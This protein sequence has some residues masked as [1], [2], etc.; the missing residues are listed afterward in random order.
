MTDDITHQATLPDLE[1]PEYHGRKPVGM[2]TSISGVGNRITREHGI[3]DRTV[4]VVEI[5]CASAGHK[6]IDDALHYVET[7]KV[8]D[9]YE[10]DRDAGARL[11]STVRS[12]YRTAADQVKGVEPL[13]GAGAIGYTD[14]SGVVLTEA[15]VAA[16]RGDPVRVLL[17]EQLTPAVIVYD[18]GHRDL[19]PDE[20]PKDTP[21][22]VVGESRYVGGEPLEV[23]ELLHHETGERL[24]LHP[25]A[26]D[27]SPAFTMPD[28]REELLVDGVPSGVFVSPGEE[29]AITVGGEPLPVTP[30]IDTSAGTLATNTGDAFYGDDDPDPSAELESGTLDDGS[31]LDDDAPDWEAPTPPRPLLPGEGDEPTEADR[32]ALKSNAKTINAALRDISDTATLRRMHSAELQGRNRRIVLADI[33]ARIEALG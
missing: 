29:I 23:V 16:L 33:T 14:A 3:G 5:R 17:T 13:P 9:F 4:A 8:L 21:R 20:Y 10:L 28:V 25:L 15:E 22:P 1:L 2:R 12:A 6:E 31:T 30:P 19:W 32:D 27:D 11:L 24:E 26:V 7:F 18:N